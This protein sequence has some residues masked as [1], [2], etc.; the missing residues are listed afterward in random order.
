[1]VVF[2]VTKQERES[3]NRQHISSKHYNWDVAIIHRVKQMHVLTL[4]KLTYQVG[5]KSLFGCCIL[6]ALKSTV[7]HNYISDS[8]TSALEI[9][10]NRLRYPAWG[11]VC[12]NLTRN[13]NPH[14]WL[15]KHSVT[16]MVNVPPHS[17][18]GSVSWSRVA[19]RA[20]QRQWYT[21]IQAIVLLNVFLVFNSLRHR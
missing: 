2:G 10:T 9:F 19:P 3:V 18:D 11:S 4:H 21:L 17:S 1:M 7:H 16:A 8:K 14:D 20:Q 13:L 5:P 12:S 6:D 15:T